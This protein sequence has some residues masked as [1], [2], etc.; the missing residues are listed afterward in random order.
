MKYW[1]KYAEQVS[2]RPATRKPTSTGDTAG[3]VRAPRPSRTTSRAIRDWALQQNFNPPPSKL[4]RIRG[5][6]VSAYYAAHPE[7]RS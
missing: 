1:S 5:E 3:R 7:A 2:A 6:I 4:G